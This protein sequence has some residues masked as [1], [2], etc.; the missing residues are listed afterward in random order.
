MRRLLI[1]AILL[2]L[3]FLG[4]AT[5]VF[6]SAAMNLPSSQLPGFSTALTFSEATPNQTV[7]P[8]TPS[9][10]GTIPQTLV[11]EG[12]TDPGGNGEITPIDT[13]VTLTLTYTI[14]GTAYTGT[15]DGTLVQDGWTKSIT[16]QDYMA[17]DWIYFSGDTVSNGLDIAS[18]G[19][20][21][22]KIETSA[23]SLAT[24][25]QVGKGAEF[26][27]TL[28]STAPEPATW[29]AMGLGLVALAFFGRRRRVAISKA[30]A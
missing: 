4:R 21:G 28:V 12:T 16:T 14:N 25:V 15:L 26:G 11:S 13:A 23:T 18:L 3:P 24:G 29:G 22:Y 27:V 7:V 6:T 20:S 8:G 10:V 1:P 19:N 17:N 30:K 9:N 5:T 2:A